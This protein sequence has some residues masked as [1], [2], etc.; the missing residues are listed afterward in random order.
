M[1]KGKGIAS[2]GLIALTVALIVLALLMTG[3][4]F[5]ARKEVRD[6][7]RMAA[8]AAIWVHAECQARQGSGLPESLTAMPPCGEAP[9]MLDPLDQPYS[10]TR[11]SSTESRICARFELPIIQN[12]PFTGV[13]TAGQPGCWDF[14]VQKVIAP[15]QQFLPDTN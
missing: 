15:E 2:G 14:V 5:H 4:P 6:R 8:I 11:L 12:H 3:G 1:A 7:K 9:T 10:Y 13:A